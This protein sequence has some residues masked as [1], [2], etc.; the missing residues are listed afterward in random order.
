MSTILVVC[1]NFADGGRCN[2]VRNLY[3]QLPSIRG[4]SSSGWAHC[5]IVA[6]LLVKELMRVCHNH[7]WNYFR[8]VSLRLLLGL[9]YRNAF[10]VYSHITLH[11]RL[12]V[13]ALPH[14]LL[15]FVELFSHTSGE[16]FFV[17]R[18]EFHGFLF[19]S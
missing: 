18:S 7:R 5:N 13:V 6:V 9:S 11:K 12:A 8:V 4:V 14:K 15:L 2:C 1:A 16:V 19:F 10:E 3:A 17:V